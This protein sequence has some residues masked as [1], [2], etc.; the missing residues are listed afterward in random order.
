MRTSERIKGPNEISIDSE[1]HLSFENLRRKQKYYFQ[2]YA[3]WKPS[4]GEKIK[5]HGKMESKYMLSDYNMLDFIACFTRKKYWCLWINGRRIIVW[6]LKAHRTWSGRRKKTYSKC[7]YG[8]E[9]HLSK[10]EQAHKEQ[11]EVS[12]NSLK[13]ISL[14]LALQFIY[15]P[16]QLP[17]ALVFF[18]PHPDIWRPSYFRICYQGFLIMQISS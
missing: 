6:T 15:S 17:M 8:G 3:T 13:T 5:A 18:S 2:Y 12:N 7:V 9:N 11:W 16:C 10:N 14:N 4:W 1:Q